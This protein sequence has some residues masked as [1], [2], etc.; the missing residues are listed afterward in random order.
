[1]DN[2]KHRLLLIAPE[3]EPWRHMIGWDE[4]RMVRKD[5]K[6]VR[7]LGMAELVSLLTEL[8]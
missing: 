8:I 2:W 6:Q 7:R 1:M 4:T 3:T 5:E